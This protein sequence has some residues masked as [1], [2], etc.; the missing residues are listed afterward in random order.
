MEAIRGDKSYNRY[1]EYG[2]TTGGAI[3]ESGSG[4]IHIYHRSE[5]DRIDN[6]LEF[7]QDAAART[8]ARTPDSDVSPYLLGFNQ[9]FNDA[10]TG[11]NIALQ[12][13]LGLPRVLT[14][15]HYLTR[16]YDA[17]NKI[18]ADAKHE[19]QLLIAQAGGYGMRKGG[20]VGNYINA[21]AAAAYV[22]VEILMPGSLPELALTLAGSG[23]GKLT[24][25][26]INALKTVPF[27]GAD[28]GVISRS[29]GTLVAAGSEA[30]LSK[31]NAK[32][33]MP[34]LSMGIVEGNNVAYRGALLDLVTSAAK[35]IA[36]ELF[37]IP[38]ANSVGRT[39]TYTGDVYAA[40][41][42][43]PVEWKY[44][45]RGDAT[46]RTEFLSSMAQERGMPAT[47]EFLNSRST[48][49]LDDIFAE[50][51]IGSQG[52]P[53]IGVS[54]NKQVA[55]YFARGPGQ[56][57]NGFV[58]TFRLESRDAATLARAN[59]ENPMSFF[60]VNPLIGLPEQEF[61]FAPNI[62]KKFIVNQ[63]P[64]GQK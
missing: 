63:V 22:G 19:T 25:A 16:K 43:G 6:M 20:I 40:D 42:V 7:L 34:S 58:T 57:Q 62:P 11:L 39:A 3:T 47:T 49:Q 30:L 28:L 41:F 4:A 56:N 36:D 2:L 27:L 50:H 13:G 60:E 38:G 5:I 54:Q 8:L 35:N 31:M 48:G 17:G 46:A 33:G 52:M 51:G 55:E 53:T 37:R 15:D 21:Y 9:I 10:K 29:T 44:F 64:V 1:A 24:G 23:L 61:L 12:V 14:N 26:G 18:L 32:I 59:Y 45:Y